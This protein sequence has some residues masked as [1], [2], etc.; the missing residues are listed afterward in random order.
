MSYYSES[1]PSAGRD[2]QASRRRRDELP[3][4]EGSSEDSGKIDRQSKAGKAKSDEWDYHAG[5]KGVMDAVYN[6]YQSR[7]LGEP[8]STPDPAPE[9]RRRKRQEIE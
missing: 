9:Y 2:P 8:A 6:E 3:S 1:S 5:G 4:D 7:Q